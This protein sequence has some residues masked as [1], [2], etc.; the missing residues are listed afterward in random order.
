MPICYGSVTYRIVTNHYGL[1]Q[2]MKKTEQQIIEAAIAVFAKDSRAPLA[3]IAKRAAISRMTLARYF[4][5]RDSLIKKIDAYL[6][7]QA[8]HNFDQA[9]QASDEPLQ[10][11]QL[12]FE[13]QL[14]Y[15]QGHVVLMKL[16]DDFFDDHHGETSGCAEINN[17]LISLLVR[18]RALGQINAD[19]PDAW[20]MMLMHG[21]MFSAWMANTSGT[22]VPRDVPRFAWESFLRAIQPAQECLHE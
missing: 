4:P 13:H 1:N 20:V 2:R 11:L 9:M 12:F 5:C 19:L 7:D 10:Q 18:L 8:M 3:H 6:I 17:R 22:V 21:T 15:V 16:N 14:Q